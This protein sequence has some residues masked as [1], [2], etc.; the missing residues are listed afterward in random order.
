MLV[1]GVRNFLVETFRGRP[2][3]GVVQRRH[4]SDYG[5]QVIYLRVCG[6]TEIFSEVYSRILEIVDAQNYKYWEYEQLTI[7][8]VFSFPPSTTFSILRSTVGA[9]SGE[10]SDEL[11]DYKNIEKSKPSSQ[12]DSKS[13][14]Q[15]NLSQSSKQS[16]KS[17]SSE[18]PSLKS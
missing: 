8:E 17:R 14:R 7:D 2:F 6:P 1:N 10:K 12:T 16:I 11:N 5:G 18:L 9:V 15:S 4:H 3:S 13:S